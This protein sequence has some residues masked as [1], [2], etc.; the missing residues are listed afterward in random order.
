MFEN[1]K[2]SGRKHHRKTDIFSGNI[3]FTRRECSRQSLG[4]D[5]KQSWNISFSA[6][7]SKK[8]SSKTVKLF[9]KLYQEG[10]SVIFVI[11]HRYLYRK[12]VKFFDQTKY[13]LT[14]GSFL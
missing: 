8:N 9:S 14:L 12:C 1:R 6:E 4:N 2:A 13:F 5:D 7:K 10:P 3:D 11:Y